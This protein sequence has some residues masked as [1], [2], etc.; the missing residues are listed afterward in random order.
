MPQTLCSVQGAVLRGKAIGMGCA[1]GL[2]YLKRPYRIVSRLRIGNE[3]IH[4]GRK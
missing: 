4:G 3:G 2:V 1:R